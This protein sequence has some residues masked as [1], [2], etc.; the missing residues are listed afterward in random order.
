[1]TMP[2]AGTSPS[3]AREALLAA[4]VASAEDGVIVID[5][6]SRIVLF[7][8]GAERMFG[9]PEIEIIGQPLEILIPAVSRTRHAALVSDFAGGTINSRRMSER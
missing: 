7:N 9:W 5:E 2:V 8:S 6:A 3:R 1:M 4:A